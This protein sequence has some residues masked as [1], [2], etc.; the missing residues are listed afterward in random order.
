MVPER[1]RHRRN[2][3]YL[4]AKKV[5]RLRLSSRL[6]RNHPFQEEGKKLLAAL[7]K[8]FE[9]SGIAIKIA[10]NLGEARW[11]KLLWNIPYN[12]MCVVLDSDTKKIMNT[13]PARKIIKELMEEVCLGAKSCGFEFES[14]AVANM[15]A[16]TDR[17]TPYEPSMK[18]DYDARRP[19]EIEY[20][21]RHPLA[22][23]KEAGQDLPAISMLAE[24]LEFWERR[25]KGAE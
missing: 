21:Y 8:D 10:N 23:A 13:P 17:M 4:L 18:L 12:G 2:V 7:Q 6:R 5:S 9:E 20:M 16:Y 22:A 11:R 14:D 25:S 1:G 19:M 24:L 15:M 3:L